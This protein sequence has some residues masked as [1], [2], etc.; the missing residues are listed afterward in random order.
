M[1]H[2]FWWYLK[3]YVLAV[4]YILGLIMAIC[5]PAWS[6]LME[7]KGPGV[8]NYVFDLIEWLFKWLIYFARWLIN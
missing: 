7:G 2:P 4:V 6:D 8:L 5:A 1:K 3:E